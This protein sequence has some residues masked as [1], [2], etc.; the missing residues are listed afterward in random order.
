MPPGTTG[1]RGGGQ[2]RGSNSRYTK[3]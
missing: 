3:L 2:C 1:V